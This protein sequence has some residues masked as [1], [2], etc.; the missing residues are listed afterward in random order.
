MSNI[1][2]QEMDLPTRPD[3]GTAGKAIKLRT[4][5]FPV[6]V[7]KGPLYEYDVTISPAG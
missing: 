6:R 7:P 2:L 4:N 5:F 3:F 1:R